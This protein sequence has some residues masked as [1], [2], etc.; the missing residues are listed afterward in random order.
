VETIDTVAR[1]G[2]GSVVETVVS[3]RVRYSASH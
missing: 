3:G 1:H 2:A